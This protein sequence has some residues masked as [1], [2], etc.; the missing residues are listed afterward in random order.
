MGVWDVWQ[1]DFSFASRV[2]DVS[3][4]AI[5][6]QDLSLLPYANKPSSGPQIRTYRKRETHLHYS[7]TGEAAQLSDDQSISVRRNDDGTF[8]VSGTTRYSAVSGSSW[9]SGRGELLPAMATLINDPMPQSQL[10]I[11][12][13]A[14]GDFSGVAFLLPGVS[15]SLCP[16]RWRRTNSG[17]SPLRKTLIWRH[18]VVLAVAGPPKAILARQRKGTGCTA[19]SATWPCSMFTRCMKP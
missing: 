15:S 8:L 5:G 4:G 18:M 9:T 19:T 1:E 3:D 14:G 6:F 10:V 11:S 7:L 12:G 13:S 2:V 16:T 17:A